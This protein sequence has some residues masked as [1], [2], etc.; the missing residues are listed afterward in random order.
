MSQIAR[1]S[2]K[3]AVTLTDLKTIRNGKSAVAR[4]ADQNPSQGNVL[5]RNVSPVYREDLSADSL[6]EIFKFDNPSCPLERIR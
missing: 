3:A 2:Y 6:P 1:G 4:L 5:R